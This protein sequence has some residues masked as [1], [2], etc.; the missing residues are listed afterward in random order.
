MPERIDPQFKIMFTYDILPEQEES[1]YRFA[2]GEWVPAM[3]NMGLYLAW[4]WLTAYGEYPSRQ[5]EFLA[6][7][8][9]TIRD[10][11]SSED[12][13]ELEDRL[14]D[15]VYNYNLKVVRYKERFQF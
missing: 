11:L 4:A 5:S 9:D 13:Q 6:E 14:L 12:F 15:F 2:L 3:Q 7:N 1:Y 10:A 8:L